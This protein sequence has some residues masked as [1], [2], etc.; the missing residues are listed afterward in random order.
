M[1]LIRLGIRIGHSRPYHPQTQGKDERFHRTL[2]NELLE[3]EGFNSL[4]ACQVA[5]DRWRELYNLVRPHESLGQQPPVSCYQPS[6]RA[7][8]SVLP[9]VEYA[10]S[11]IVRIVSDKGDISYKSKRHFVGQGLKSQQVVL[12]PGTTDGVFDVYFCHHH[13]Q[14]IDLRT[15]P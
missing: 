12:K 8:P 5:F 10:S 14:Q 1:W 15:V 11:D 13:I 4:S 9:A 3:R 7:L 2:K 6:G